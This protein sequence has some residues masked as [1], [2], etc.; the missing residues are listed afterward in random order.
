MLCWI[1]RELK[2]V[3]STAV[4]GF[5]IKT[6]IICHSG[7]II[8][9]SLP[10]NK[11]ILGWFLLLTMISVRNSEVVMKFAQIITFRQ[12]GLNPHHDAVWSSV[13]FSLFWDLTCHT[14]TSRRPDYHPGV[15]I[16]MML[17]AKQNQNFFIK[18]AWF[19][20]MSFSL[21]FFAALWWRVQRKV[22]P[23]ASRT[24]AS[25]NEGSS[26]SINVMC[27]FQRRFIA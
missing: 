17:P 5:W 25:S 11:A 23:V 14:K 24:Y 1:S 12:M 21:A 16:K 8:V 7:Q 6:Y 15:F 18:K 22:H 4:F 10:W 9:N 27:K 13:H 20:F 3:R 2:Y 19:G 26:R